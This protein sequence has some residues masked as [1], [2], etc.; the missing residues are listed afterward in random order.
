MA[1]SIR[2]SRSRQQYR[3]TRHGCCRKSNITTFSIRD[4]GAAYHNSKYIAQL[5]HDLIESLGRA[6]CQRGP[7]KVRP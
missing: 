4:P 6:A 3:R 2:T 7:G 1:R 5:L